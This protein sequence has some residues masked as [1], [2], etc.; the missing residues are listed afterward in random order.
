M[1]STRKNKQQVKKNEKKKNGI[2]ERYT[3]RK[4][5]NEKEKPPTGTHIDE[6]KKK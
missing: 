2:R 1:E 3:E 6:Q 5:E 4:K